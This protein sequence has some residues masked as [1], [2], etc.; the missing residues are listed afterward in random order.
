M[1]ALDDAHSHGPRWWRR[2]IAATSIESSGSV[3]RRRWPS[4]S[5][6]EV[7]VPT[8]G[9]SAAMASFAATVNGRLARSFAS[10]RRVNSPFNGTWLVHAS[11]PVCASSYDDMAPGFDWRFCLSVTLWSRTASYSTPGP[12]NTLMCDRLRTG[13][14]SR[15]VTS[16]QGQLSLPY[17]CRVPAFLLAWLTLEGSRSL[18]SGSRQHCD[19]KWHWHP[20]ALGV[21]TVYTKSPII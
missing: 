5:Y 2:T 12:V 11:H 17:L 16:H 6:Q 13:T 20:V 1:H 18:V 15:Y 19:P 8:A 14:P 21:C 10:S 4:V 3:I 9:P 7:L